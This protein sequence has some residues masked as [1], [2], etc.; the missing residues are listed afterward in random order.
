MPPPEVWGPAV[1]TLFHTLAEKINVN[2][3][4]AV[5]PS[6]FNM[7][8][9]ISKFLPCPECSNDASIFLAKV[10]VSELKTK[11]SLKAMLCIFHNTVNAKK[12]KPIFSYSNIRVYGKYNLIKVIN[13]FISQYQTKG[14]MK[15]LTESFQRQFIIKDFKNWFQKTIKAFS[16]PISVPTP[17]P[18]AIVE[19][20]VSEPVTS[21][22]EPVTSLEEPIEVQE[23]EI[24][25]TSLEEPAIEDSISEPVEEPVTSLEEPIEVQE[26][27]IPVSNIEEPTIEDSISEPVE[28]PIS[29]I[30][31]P[32][33]VQEQE[34]PV[35]NI[36][37]PTIEDS[38]SEPVE[39]PIISSSSEEQ[40]SVEEDISEINDVILDTNI[41]TTQVSKKKNKKN[42][43]KNKK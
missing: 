42:K 28:E 17:L 39:E 25:V 8:I 26:Q 37:E 21:V 40:A 13:N 24:P 34:I 30:E 16:G 11:E 22:E 6:L 3:Y 4:P 7:I 9:K 43:N 20:A 19:E 1:W 32:I 12:R 41:E 2:A 36:E 15:L 14:N 31:E 5:F 33:E 18:V 29:N 35:S 38:I 23:Q 10:K 27:E